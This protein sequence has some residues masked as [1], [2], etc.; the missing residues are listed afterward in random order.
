MQGLLIFG[1]GLAALCPETILINQSTEPWNQEDK[2]ILSRNYGFCTR[3]M[4]D[5]LPCIAKFIKLGTRR[6]YISCGA[7]RGTK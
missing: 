2:T 6:Y 5:E 3:K 4:G 7:K 1:L